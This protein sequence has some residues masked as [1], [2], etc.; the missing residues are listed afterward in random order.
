MADVPK[1]YFQRFFVLAG[2]IFIALLLMGAFWMHNS[3]KLDAVESNIASKF[4]SFEIYEN[5]KYLPSIKILGPKGDFVNIQKAGGRYIILNIWATWCSPCVKELPSLQRLSD[6]LPYESGWKVMAVSVDTKKNLPKVAKFA[7]HYKVDDIANY[8]DYNLEL[9]NNI[10]VDRLPMTL[11]I[12][13]S[14]RIL[15]E[16]HGAAIWHDRDM[17]DF[18]E[19]VRKVH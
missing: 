18:L 11:I 19:L 3:S 16:I 6:I 9:Q 17:V 4:K 14:G 10:D 15:Y 12:G 7:A 5:E 13:K 1:R 2:F 8:H